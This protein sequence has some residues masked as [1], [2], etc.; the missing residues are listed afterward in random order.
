[1]CST[2]PGHFIELLSKLIVYYT[3][4]LFSLKKKKKQGEGNIDVRLCLQLNEQEHMNRT[5]SYDESTR[6]GV[7]ST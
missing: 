5:C 7:E 4:C 2:I 6:M 1:M 3:L